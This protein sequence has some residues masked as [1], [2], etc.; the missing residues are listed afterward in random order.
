MWLH[1]DDFSDDR[2]RRIWEAI[3]SLR[4]ASPS[5][6]IDYTLLINR[7]LDTKEL[8]AVGGMTYLSSLT[9]GLPRAVNAEHYARIV[10]DKALLR[11]LI[12]TTNNIVQ[13]AIDGAWSEGE[14]NLRDGLA[15]FL[16][17]SEAAILNVRRAEV[18]GP[19]HVSEIV[20]EL[21]TMLAPGGRT[22]GVLP[23]SVPHGLLS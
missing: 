21:T 4:R 13:Q 18:G 20:S 6:P 17:R 1:S 10:E 23:P 5:I 11:R 3:K 19:V 9:D 16:D 2:N 15:A 14:E 8:E 7:L 12:H 22:L